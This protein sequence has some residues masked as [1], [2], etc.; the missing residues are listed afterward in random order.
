M[1]FRI[2]F[3]GMTK[4]LSL[5][6]YV[7]VK[8][9]RRNIICRGHTQ[10]P[11][12]TDHM[13]ISFRHWPL[14]SANSDMRPRYWKCFFELFWTK[15]GVNFRHSLNPRRVIDFFLFFF[16]STIVKQF[17]LK[18]FWVVLHPFKSIFIFRKSGFLKLDL[19]RHVK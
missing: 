5:A 16:R 17:V 9:E 11:N 6:T 13:K 10:V 14:D 2:I 15:R 19:I 8:F 18:N 1:F 3:T 4:Y 7:C 12:Q